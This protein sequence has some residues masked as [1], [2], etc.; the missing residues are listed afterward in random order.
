MDATRCEDIA[1]RRR[2]NC[3]VWD[4]DYDVKEYRPKKRN[5][6]AGAAS[7]ADKAIP[8]PRNADMENACGGGAVVS[9]GGI[10]MTTSEIFGFAEETDSY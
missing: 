9:G 2:G 8:F 3:M 4:T 7:N 1:R 10:M 5:G 6:T